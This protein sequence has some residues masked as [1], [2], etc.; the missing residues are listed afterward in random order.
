[1]T[2]KV[3]DNKEFRYFIT[4]R[5]FFTIAILMQSVIIGWQVYEITKDAFSLGM[6]GLFEAIPS[7]ITALVSG[8]IVDHQE[9]KKVLAFAYILMLF[10]STSLF[11]VSSDYIPAL[12]AVKISAMYGIIFLTGISRGFYMPAAQALLGQIVDKEMYPRA[13]SWNVSTWQVGAISGP[14]IGGFIYGF[15]GTSITYLVI[16]TFI[17]IAVTSLMM[18]SRKP[19]PAQTNQPIFERLTGGIK[20]VFNRKIILGSMT[21]DLFAVLFGGATALL[22]VFASDILDVGPKGLGVLRAAPSVGAVLMAFYLTKHPPVKGTGKLLFTNVAAFGVCMIIFAISQN[23]YLS[24]LALALSGMFDSVSVVIRQTILQIFT[25]D[26]MKGRVAAVNSIFI[27]SSN[28]IG[29][30]E[31]GLA[32]KLLGTVPSV[33]FGGIMTL[34]IVL[35]ASFAFPSLRKMELKEK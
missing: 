10:C 27:G 12:S 31:S 15:L 24:V 8:L 19:K 35:S 1:M 9:R 16:I 21:L 7:I 11:T 32:A 2:Q 6:V 13:V 5:F 26:E 14:A 20:F 3:F 30:F 33:I 18:I 25:P 22:P 28:E 23:F 17:I 34:I 4:A 29:A